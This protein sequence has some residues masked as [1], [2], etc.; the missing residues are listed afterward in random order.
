ML[1]RRIFWIAAVVLGTVA[2]QAAAQTT[3]ATGRVLV[4]STERPIPGATVA[5]PNLRLATT[6]DSLGRFWLRGVQPGEQVIVVRRIGY[7]PFSSVI[8]IPSGEP[9][10]ADF[11]LTPIVRKLE[12]V[13]VVGERVSPKLVE[14]EERRKLG[15]GHFLTAEDLEKQNTSRVTTSLAKL[16]GLVLVRAGG[17]GVYVGSSRGVQ[18]VLRGN[19][20]KPCGADVYLDGIFVGSGAE[21]DL[22]KLI[23]KTDISAIEWYAS[24]AQMPMKYGGTKRGCAVVVIWTH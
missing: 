11:L 12:N 4:D 21:V 19:G 14:F 16:P 18:S 20:S 13:K 24:T 17:G 3:S 1:A 22:D 2:Q 10:D 8:T 5:I 7:A 15:I 23:Q 9:L 6:T